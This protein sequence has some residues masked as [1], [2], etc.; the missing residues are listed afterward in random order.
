MNKKMNKNENENKLRIIKLDSMQRPHI[1]ICPHH[2]KVEIVEEGFYNP[3]GTLRSGRLNTEDTP[4]VTACGC[5]FHVTDVR[6]LAQAKDEFNKAY[7]V[8]ELVSD[9]MDKYDEGDN[10]PEKEDK[11]FSQVWSL[12]E[13]IEWVDNLYD[14]DRGV[15]YDVIMDNVDMSALSKI[16]LEE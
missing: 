7:C 6:G 5:E 3:H 16:T 8:L 15:K 14:V 11:F 10:I 4:Y 12:V 13:D 2:G 1:G 9:L